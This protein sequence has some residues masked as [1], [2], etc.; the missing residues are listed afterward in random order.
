VRGVPTVV[1]RARACSLRARPNPTW[2]APHAFSGQR[3]SRRTK[4]VTAFPV[5]SARK[6]R[7]SLSR[8]P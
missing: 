1:A 4:P 2:S 6:T 7:I 5:P 8:A 3:L